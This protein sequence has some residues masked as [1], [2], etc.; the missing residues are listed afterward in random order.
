MINEIIE[1]SVKDKYSQELNETLDF[2]E[3]E[4]AKEE[5]PS[6]IVTP[7]YFFL[8]C[9]MYKG[10]NVL[11]G[12]TYFLT[13]NNILTLQASIYNYLS[14]KSLTAIKPNRKIKYDD[15][16]TR[17]IINAE[18]E[19]NNLGEYEITT[20]HVLLAML[21]PNILQIGPINKIRKILNAKQITYEKYVEA[22]KLG[23]E[24]F[25]KENDDSNDVVKRVVFDLNTVPNGNELFQKLINGEITPEELIQQTPELLKQVSE[26][27]IPMPLPMMPQMDGLN[28]KLTNK[29]T[30]TPYIDEFCTNLNSLAEQ[31]K[32]DNLVGRQNELDEIIRIL[33]RRKKNNAI[34]VGRGGIGKTII[35]ENLATKIVNQDV[36]DFLLNKI[37]I[38]LDI[39]AL[40]A[41][42]TLRGMFEDRVKNLLNEIKTNGNYILFIDNIGS[43]FADKFKNDYDISSML[44]HALEEGEVQVIGTADNKSFRKS[45]DKDPSLSR[46]FQKINMEPPTIEETYSIIN[47][48]KKYY[49]D[50]HHVKYTEKAIKSCVEL[51][52]RYLPEKNLPDSAIDVMDETGAI[53]SI[54]NNSNSNLKNLKNALS[55]INLQIKKEQEQENFKKVDELE[56]IASSLK[57]QID[58]EN[59]NF[60]IVDVDE[61]DVL[62]LMSKKT[63]IPVSKLSADDKKKL[64]T[65]DERLKEDI[66]GQDEAIETICKALKRNRIGLSNGKCLYSCIEVGPTG[67]GKTLLAKKLAKEMFGTEDAL[68]RFDMSEYHEKTAVNKLIGSNP[69]YVGYEDGGLLTEAVKNRKYCVLLLDEIEKADPEVYNIFLQVLDEGFLTDNFGNRV[70]FKNVIVIF[71]SNVGTK[72]A[73]DF[74]KGIGFKTDENAN[75]K[76]ILL[77]EFKN[78]FP[79]EFINRLTNVI[80]FNKLTD[81]N[82][83][84]IIKL[85][86]SKLS[87]RL[88]NIGYSI[89]YDDATIDYLLDIVKTEKEYGARPIIRTIQEEIE[90]KITD[91]LLENEYPTNYCFNITKEEEK[92]NLNIK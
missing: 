36:P 15:K 45:F 33:G 30:K 66:I 79:P 59:K 62:D 64:L 40:T 53:V 28:T 69:G 23:D 4:I 29:K 89:S 52:N 49:E 78:K 21:N 88:T 85:E 39:T 71:T 73:S 60:T 37:V 61:N 16:L 72:A 10:S 87:N 5:L 44:S 54:Q 9:L 6:A 90:D 3:N 55:E 11:K 35:C 65:I 67:T 56:K 63:N 14:T 47:G 84:D 31:G 32:I 82:L 24:R 42:T 17:F 2:M 20:E 1:Q 57:Q 80:Y 7:E 48:I 83:K 50:F 19:M 18:K 41:G 81:D 43:I 51:S 68:I 27:G 86:I 13:P 25:N 76:R 91:L 70:D 22:L 34:L 26:M 8:A 74:G 92:N 75:T 46:R 38:S 77:K 58:D 12:L